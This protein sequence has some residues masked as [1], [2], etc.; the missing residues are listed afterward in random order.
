MQKFAAIINKERITL[1]FGYFH[2]IIAKKGTKIEI[3]KS[4]YKGNAY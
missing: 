2:A 1:K 4:I 3:Y